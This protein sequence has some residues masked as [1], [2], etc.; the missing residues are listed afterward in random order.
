MADEGDV[1]SA[2]FVAAIEEGA[3]TT[4]V[5]GGICA[6]GGEAELDTAAGEGTMELSSGCARAW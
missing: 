1:V 3:P 6:E 2:I 5:V 4:N